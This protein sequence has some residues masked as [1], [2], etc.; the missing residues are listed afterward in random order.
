MSKHILDLVTIAT[1]STKHRPKPDLRLFTHVRAYHC[2][3]PVDQQSYLDEGIRIGRPCVLESQFR[4]IFKDFGK[5]LLD[6][7]VVK[8]TVAKRNEVDLALDYRWLFTFCPHY[9]ITGSELIREFAANIT[10]EE[11]TDQRERLKGIGIPSMV[12]VD[13][14]IEEINHQDLEYIDSKLQKLANGQ[15]DEAFDWRDMF[16]IT[17]SLR[18]TVLPEWIVD[19]RTLKVENGRLQLLE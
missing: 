5:R 17:V 2:G 13:V 1:D 7:A 9:A 6:E 16:D 3:R 18:K 10:G 14:P 12:V 11:N 15:Y 19:I 8:T 4:D